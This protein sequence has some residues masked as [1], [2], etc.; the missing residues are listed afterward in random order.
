M[1]TGE[2]LWI[3]MP[4]QSSNLRR[5]SSGLGATRSLKPLLR[6]TG[7]KREI[8]TRFGQP[9]SGTNCKYMEIDLLSHERR[10]SFLGKATQDHHVT[11]STGSYHHIQQILKYVSH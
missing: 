1:V 10:I 2:L 7:Q 4:N 9:T 3:G 8:I 11:W 6:R 5:L